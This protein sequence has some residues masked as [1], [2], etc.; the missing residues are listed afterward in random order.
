VKRI[1]LALTLVLLA[2]CHVGP[3]YRPPELP[4]HAEGPLVSVNESTESRIPPPDTWWQLYGDAQMNALVAEAFTA[5][6]DLA[7]ARANLAA[8]HA[9]LTA[10]RSERYPSTQIIAG[11][12]RGRDPTTDEILELNGQRPENFWLFEDLFQVGYEVDLFGRVHRQVEAAGANAEAAAAFRDSVQAVV[13]SETVRA[14]AA[15]CALGEQVAVSRHSLE[16]VS[17]EADITRRRFEAGAGS[18]YDV[19]RA[20]ALAEQVGADIP[21]LEGQRRAALFTLAALLGRTPA[22]APLET[23][24]CTVAPHLEALLPV[25][26]GTTLIR[27]RPD[28]RQAERRLAAATAQIGV[29][30]AD[31]YPT[32]K[33]VGFYGGAAPQMSDLGTNAGLAWGIGPQISWNFFNQSAARAR[34]RKATAGEA[35]ALANFDSTVLGA[36]KEIEQA[37]SIYDAGL[38]NHTSLIAA[39]QQIREAFDIARDEYSAGALSSLDLLTTEQSLVTLDSAVAASESALVIDQI[40]VFNALGGG[41]G[42]GT[43]V[44]TR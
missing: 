9:V 11:G 44:A 18:S 39:R 2:S 12:V 26:D 13:A 34:V 27:R 31:L 33:L 3:N 20:Q 30:T 25:G 1:G 4:K 29:A 10:A 36:L 8:A 38:R 6:R 22:D 5:N 7:V 15:I 41:W 17:H 35:A 19:K 24:R 23:E 16:V 43:P 42:D 28:I 21:T 37:L 32:V 40:A 14:Y